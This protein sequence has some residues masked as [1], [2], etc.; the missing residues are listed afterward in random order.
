MPKKPLIMMP[1]FELTS[2]SDLESGAL[3]VPEGLYGFLF[4]PPA[5]GYLDSILKI[6]GYG[7]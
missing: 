3:A 5:A 2:L 1:C 4:Q 7:D 6:T